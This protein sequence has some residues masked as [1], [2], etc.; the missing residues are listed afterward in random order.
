[1]A[2][3]AINHPL[4]PKRRW[5]LKTAV[6]LGALGSALG[7]LVYWNRGMSDGRLTDAGKDVFHG[8]ARGFLGAM[9]PADPAARER[10]LSL[11]IERLEGFLNTL[12]DALRIQVSALVG[13]L[14]NKPTRYLVTG[15]SSNWKEA[16]DQ[17]VAQALAYMQLNDLPSH[18][19]SYQVMRSITLMSFFTQQDNW[20]LTGYPGPIAI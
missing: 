13:L 17:D 19:L 9:L 1:M 16:T 15:L 5:F 20:S 14:G 6:A 4:T 10:Y 3:P 12:P 8:L 18:R 2:D 7:G 11:H